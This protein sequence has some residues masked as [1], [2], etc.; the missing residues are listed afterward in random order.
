MGLIL[1]WLV[2]LFR[3]T[4]STALCSIE[5]QGRHSTHSQPKVGWLCQCHLPYQPVS[6][7]YGGLLVLL[8]YL[9]LGYSRVEGCYVGWAIGPMGCYWLVIY[10]YSIG[11]YCYYE[12][13]GLSKSICYLIVQR[14]REEEEEKKILVPSWSLF[15][16]LPV[17]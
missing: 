12:I 10:S 17:E 2:C 14:G 1:A 5:S 9:V 4:E 8:S 16:L 3:L 7:P 15:F 11:D 13:T 6:P